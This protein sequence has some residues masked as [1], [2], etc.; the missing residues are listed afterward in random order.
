MWPCA[1]ELHSLTLATHSYMYALDYT[2]IYIYVYVRV[3]IPAGTLKMNTRM[4]IMICVFICS[5]KCK[6]NIAHYIQKEVCKMLW[7]TITQYSSIELQRY[8]AIAIHT[9]K[10]EMLLWPKVCCFSWMLYTRCYCEL[11]TNVVYNILVPLGAMYSALEN[12]KIP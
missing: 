2:Y 12:K 3:Y 6:L 4:F 10:T 5:E 1:M 9:V 11:V 8:I 7:N